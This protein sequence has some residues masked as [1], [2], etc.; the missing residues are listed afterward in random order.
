MTTAR[1]PWTVTALM[2]LGTFFSMFALSTLLEGAGWLRTV[3]LVLLIVTAANLGVRAATR[4]RFLPTFATI[5][6]AIFTMV[7]LFAVDEEG[8]GY[9]LPTPSAIGDLWQ[10]FINGAEYATQTAAPAATT[11][12]LVS[13][14]TG[15]AVAVFLVADHLAASWRAVAVSGVVLL[16]PWTPAIF[17]QY[18]VPMWALFATAACWMVAM[19][20]ARSPAVTSRS[21]PLMGAALATVAALVATVLVAPAALGGNGWGAIPRFNAPSA[22]ETSTR[23]NLALDLRNSLTV[24]S[25]KIV[26]TY[27]STGAHPD[28][29]RFYTLRDFDGSGWTRENADPT[30]LVP[31]GDGVLWPED[32]NDWQ[33]QDKVILSLDI[34]GAAERNLPLPTVPR[35]VDVDDSWQ[36]SPSL[37]EATTQGDG[38]KGMSLSIVA[39]LDYFTADSLINSQELI[40]TSSQTPG[41][42]YT[43][44][45]TSVDTARI[46]GLAK[47]ITADATNRYEQA[48]ALQDYLRSGGNF[49]Y[50]TSVSPGQGD[51]VSTFLDD[52]RGYCVHFA[53]TMVVLARSLG[54]P[55]RMGMGY[56]GGQLTDDDVWEV[57]GS[58]AHAWPELYFPGQGWVRF[59]PTPAV[60]TGSAP[61]YTVQRQDPGSIPIPSNIAV[62][63]TVPSTGPNVPTANPTANPAN[64]PADSGVSWFVLVAVAVL[65]IAAGFG[66][67]ALRRRS[68]AHASDHG[69]E[70]AWE[71]L[72]SRLPESMRWSPSL[73]PIEAAE[74]LT[75]DMAAASAPF[76]RAAEVSLATLR[77][78][79]SDYRYAPPSGAEEAFDEESLHANVQAVVEEANE[80]VRSRSDRVGARSAP[81]HDS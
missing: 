70:A 69:P 62:P 66:F 17:L 18:Q 27:V 13:L 2:A 9:L 43:E 52:R 20:A 7:P 48:V 3:A 32:I 31:A 56:L 54:I 28:V 39:A 11:T 50:D 34:S 38:T 30:D 75:H 42:E 5:A 67:W 78:A 60:Q 16:L 47:D 79:V 10:A 21:A 65:A 25:T 72:R 33:G 22:L 53:T 80:A 55:S 64:T 49:T 74:R 44:I 35:S 8:Q 24:N 1:T 73:T 45:P 36:Y 61:S 14:L 29:F 41:P 58:S 51:S 37:D 77:D 59:E 26:M 71:S 81:Q 46:T 68:A 40:G 15:F 19:G 63:T 76:T 57:K 4:S 23:L 12:E 6:A